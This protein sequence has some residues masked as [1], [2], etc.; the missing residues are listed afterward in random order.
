MRTDVSVCRSCGAEV[1]WVIQEKSGKAQPVDAAPNP[2][3][4][5]VLTGKKQRSRAGTITPVARTLA[6]GQMEL[7][8]IADRYMPHHATCPDVA[9][10][11]E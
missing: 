9:R 4:N 10:W 3:G 5:V 6:I 1:L 11:R 8:P 7:V 2:D